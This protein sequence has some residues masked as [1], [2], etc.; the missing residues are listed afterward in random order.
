[1]KI[2]IIQLA[3]LGDIYLSW[4]AIR[5]LKRLQPSAEI[6]LLTR[7][8][9]V[10][11]ADG[12]RPYVN[13]IVTLPVK[14]V[15]APLVQDN[16]DVVESHTRLKNFVTELRGRGFDKVVNFSFSPASS[17]ITHL[18][19][20]P[21]ENVAGYSRTED[22]FL[23]I[24]DDMSAYFYAQVGPGKSNRFHL[25]EIF[26]TL[27]GVDLIDED[28]S[29]PAIS[30]FETGI[31]GEFIA[32]HIGASEGHK[33][34]SPEKWT[35][36]FSQLKALRP[37]AQVALI[38]SEAEMPI[39]DRIL[40]SVSGLSL[41]SFVG[42]TSLHETLSIVDQAEILVGPDS[43]PMHMASLTKTRCLNLS[44]GRVNFWE[45][46][47]RASGSVVMRAAAETDLVSDR[48]ARVIV[49]LFDKQRPELGLVQVQP[50]TPSYSGLFPKEAEFQWKL[51]QA[52][53]QGTPF[54]EPVSATFWEAHTQ[55]LE[56]NQFLIDQMTALQNGASLQDK[57][58]LIDR[59]EEVIDAIG[60]LVPAW[61]A[62]LRWYQTEKVRIPPGDTTKVLARTL[63]IQNLL[64]QVL[65]VY[66]DMKTVHA[67]PESEAR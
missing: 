28:W 34:L 51:V 26:G 21:V 63:E 48:V 59:G 44:V 52:V 18:M 55:L 31:K 50:G 2:L 57:A 14:D 49:T 4:P 65:L 30:R 43:A 60:K 24:P 35:S 58:A 22:G 7:D 19:Q 47:P 10:A 53:Y 17:Y 32:C 9:F 6:T 29:K 5:A 64:H 40:S 3:R 45:T 16:M 37:Q 46:G 12:L 67:A 27:C 42:K 38:G 1:M 23:A 33:T 61:G 66:S 39:A 56:V 41:Y 15:L 62:V 11:A 13:E 20:L 8:R 25:A 36:I 54:P